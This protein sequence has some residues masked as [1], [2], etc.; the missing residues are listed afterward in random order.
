MAREL[1]SQGA[2]EHGS[3]QC[4][5]TSSV[6]RLRGDLGW[7]AVV[8]RSRNCMRAGTLVTPFSTACF[9]IRSVA[10]SGGH[11]R[12]IRFRT[13][14]GKAR[15]C[16]CGWHCVD[17]GQCGSGRH[18]RVAAGRLCARE[19]AEAVSH[20]VTIPPHCGCRPGGVARVA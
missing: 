9:P 18:G 8:F 2:T 1:T 7:S 11:I 16:Q 5:A 4:R 13:N 10:S 19:E 15:M 3:P 20:A 6:R 12:H 14:P 17:G